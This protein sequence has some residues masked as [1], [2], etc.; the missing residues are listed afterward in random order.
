MY[1]LN[2]RVDQL[3]SR[4]LSLKSNIINELGSLQ[5]KR[6]LINLSTRPRDRNNVFQTRMNL[7]LIEQK[8]V[9]NMKLPIMS[10]K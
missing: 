9:T 6:Q 3:Q 10:S 7:E 2:N 8:K 5:G 4:N 1:Y